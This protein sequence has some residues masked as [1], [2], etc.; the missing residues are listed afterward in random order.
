M[1]IDGASRRQGRPSAQAD[2]RPVRQACG[3]AARRGAL[4]PERFALQFLPTGE[5]LIELLL[6]F[7]MRFVCGV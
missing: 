2:E 3:E 6:G 5:Q 7:S 4:L 1:S